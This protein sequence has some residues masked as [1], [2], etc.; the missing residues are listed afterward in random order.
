MKE[1][2]LTAA[3]IIAA[4]A[5]SLCCIGPVIAVGLGLGAFGLAAAFESTRPYLLGLTFV[6]LAVFNYGDNTANVTF[7]GRRVTAQQIEAKVKA[8]AVSWKRPVNRPLRQKSRRKSRPGTAPVR[9]R[10]PRAD[11]VSGK[12]TKP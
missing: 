12:S 9:L 4:I 1:K 8:A 7:D 3:S 10:T 2:S 6:I 5:A 11:A